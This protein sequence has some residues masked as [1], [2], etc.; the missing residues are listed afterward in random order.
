V[1][2]GVPG[3]VQPEQ[4]LKPLLEW[5]AISKARHRQRSWITKTAAYFITPKVE[6]GM[7]GCKKIDG[8]GEHKGIRKDFIP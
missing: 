3:T 4:P 5:E 7:G 1:A 8:E 2:T 6:D